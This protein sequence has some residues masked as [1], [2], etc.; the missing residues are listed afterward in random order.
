V[1]SFSEREWAAKIFSAIVFP[2]NS[3][4]PFK[5]R[6]LVYFNFYMLKSFYS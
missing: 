4:S 3:G 2:L 5:I 1:I 6:S